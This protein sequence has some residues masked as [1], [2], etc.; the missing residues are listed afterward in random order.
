MTRQLMNLIASKHCK[1]VGDSKD[2]FLRAFFFSFFLLEH[3]SLISYSSSQDFF[4]ANS[5]KLHSG[6]CFNKL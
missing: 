3:L 5:Q 1:I 6:S 4:A 2:I